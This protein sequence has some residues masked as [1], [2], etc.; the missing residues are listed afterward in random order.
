MG[1]KNLKSRRDR[2]KH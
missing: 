1:T 2:S